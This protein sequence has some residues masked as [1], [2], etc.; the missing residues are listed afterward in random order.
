MGGLYRR[1]VKEGI[2]SVKI[3]S[4]NGSSPGLFL[5]VFL[6]PLVYSIIRDTR[7]LIKDFCWKDVFTMPLYRL[8][9]FWGRLRGTIK[10]IHQRKTA[11]SIA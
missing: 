8:V 11:S 5:K 6:Y 1:H 9:L 10:G 7:D 4:I 2:D 3:F